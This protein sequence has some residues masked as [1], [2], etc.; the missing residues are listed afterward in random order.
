MDAKFWLNA[1]DRMALLTAMLH[2]LCGNAHVS[3]E[4]DLSKLDFS[5][6]PGS[7]TEENETLKRATLLPELNF[8]IVPLEI[9]TIPLI[10]DQLVLSKSTDLWIDLIHIQMEKNGII[11][12]AAYDNFHPDCVVSG[13]RISEALLERLVSE[14]TI[15]SF[16]PANV[17]R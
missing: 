17:N 12:F 5:V 14:G 10:L 6:I 11:E 2:E 13:S 4:G 8:M 16:I 3:F 7:T 15:Q 1:K 9:N